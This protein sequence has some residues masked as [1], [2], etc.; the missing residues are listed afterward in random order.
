MPRTPDEAVAASLAQTRNVPD[1]CQLT[2]RTWLDAASA[3]DRDHDGDADAY[4]GWLSEPI[5][6]RHLDRNP[7]AG[8]PVAWKGGSSGHGHRALSL[9]K[10]N[11][12]TYIRSTDA[13]GS[14]VVATVPLSWVEDHW[15]LTYLGWST[16]IDGLPIPPNVEPKPEPLDPKQRAKVIRRTARRIKAKRPKWAARLLAWADR[17]E[18]KAAK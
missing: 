2:V 9:G 5:S 16:T 15:G 3:G 14:G 6:A 13:G 18:K 17:I 11:G 4:D 7:P 12:V 1:T 8:Y 10:R